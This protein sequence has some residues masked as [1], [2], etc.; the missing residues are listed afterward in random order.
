MTLEMDIERTA[1]NNNRMYVKFLRN[2]T[3]IFLIQ[4]AAKK[5]STQLWDFEKIHG[6]MVTS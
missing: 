3:G 6:S 5:K 1:R 2:F 4:V